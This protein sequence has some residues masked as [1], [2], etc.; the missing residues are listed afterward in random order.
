MHLP[1]NCHS[2]TPIPIGAGV[3]GRASFKTSVQEWPPSSASCAG[4]AV[5]ALR[6]MLVQRP[7]WQMPMG[8]LARLLTCT[9]AQDP[10]L[11]TRTTRRLLLQFRKGHHQLFA[12]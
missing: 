4:A 7:P 11:Q 5:S 10:P 6:V 3:G 12:T 9:S 1:G 2:P 8:S